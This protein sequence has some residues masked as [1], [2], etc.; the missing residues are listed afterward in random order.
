[1]SAR[2][3]TLSLYF[4]CFASKSAFFRWQMSINDA[5]WTVAPAVLASSI[6]IFLL[7]TFV[8]FHGDFFS[9]FP[10]SLSTA[11]FAARIFIAWGIG[12]NLWTNCSAVMNFHP[13]LQ[14]GLHD[15]AVSNFP[16]AFLWIHQLL[17]CFWLSWAAMLAFPT[18]FPILSP[19]PPLHL[20]FFNAWGIGMNLW[21]RL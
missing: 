4:W 20:D 9:N 15:D 14:Y 19:L 3:T 16:Y 8:K 1:M 10:H 12:I 5:K 7:L 21:T 11:A 6:T 13:F 17:S 18:V 2:S